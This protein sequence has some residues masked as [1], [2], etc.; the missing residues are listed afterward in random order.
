MEKKKYYMQPDNLDNYPDKKFTGYYW[1]S[2]QTNPELVDG[3]FTLPKTGANPFVI[4]AN[5]FANDGLISVSVEHI[6]GKY[7]IGIVDWK[8][9]DKSIVFDPEE[10]TYLTH[11]LDNHPKAK[12]VRAWIPVEDPECEGM[13]VLQP[14]WRAFKGFVK[15]INLNPEIE[16]S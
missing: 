6:D 11:R 10:P 13:E 2:D 3:I 7:L 16:Q 15:V 14:A 9:V 12:F 5:L 1:M 4:E 8:E